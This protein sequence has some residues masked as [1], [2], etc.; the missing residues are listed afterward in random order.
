MVKSRTDLFK[1]ARLKVEPY[2]DSLIPEWLL[3]IK[4]EI[5]CEL[6]DSV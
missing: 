4:V 1:G 2:P 5:N 3:I 6:K